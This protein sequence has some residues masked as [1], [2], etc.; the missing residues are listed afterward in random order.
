MWAIEI[1]DLRT[2]RTYKLREYF[3]DGRIL[4]FEYEELAFRFMQQMTGELL[5]N[6]GVS[7]RT[8]RYSLD[9]RKDKPRKIS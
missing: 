6:L 7:L 5:E 2:G 3:L 9:P 4:I 8:V 1:K